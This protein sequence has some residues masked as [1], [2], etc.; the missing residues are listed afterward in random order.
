MKLKTLLQRNNNTFSKTLMAVILVFPGLRAA[1]Q[2][3][4]L[5]AGTTYTQNFDGLSN[6]AAS[7]TNSLT[8]PG[9]YMS[10]SGGGARDNGLYAVDNGATATGDTYSY[11]TAG[12]TDRALGSLR[13]GNLIPLYGASFTNNTGATIT[14]L[15]V[16]YTGEQW[17]LGTAGRTD[18]LNFEYSINATTFS[19]G[20]WTGLSALN[21]LTPTTTGALANKDGNAAG[22]RTA[23]TGT[24]T[25][26]SIANGATVWIR[27]VDIDATG[28][29]DGLAI[30]D[31]SITPVNAP[32]GSPEIDLQG[33]AVSI[34]NNSTTTSLAD[35]TDF[36][37]QSVCTGVVSHIFSILNT[38][39]ANLNLSGTPVVTVS[40]ANASD[41]TVSQPSSTVV[42]SG[43][44]TTFTVTFDPS[45]AG[46]RSA[47]LS[48]ANNDSD[49]NPYVFAIRGT[50][51]DV[52]LTLNTQNNVACHGGS[53]GAISVTASGN[54][55]L[56]YDWAPGTPTG[57]GTPAISGLSAGVY[58]VTV[59]DAGTCS[60]TASYTITEPTAIAVSVASQSGASCHGGNNGGATISASGGTGTL[61]YS[62][63]PSGG[64][65]ATASGLSAGV[66]TVTV[67]DANSCSQTQTVSI[68]EP[69]AISTSV[70]TQ[71][72]VS[73]NGGSN[74]GATISASGGTGTLV[75][76]WAPS[77]GT[78]ATA[79]GLATGV[80][81]VTVTDANTCSKTQT[82]SISEPTALAVSV[83]TQ[84]NVSCN[85]GNNGGA[86]LSANGGTGTLTY[87]WFPSGGTAATASG[88]VAGTYTVTVTDANTCAKS[89][90]L[91]ITQPAAIAVSVVSQ[92]SVSCQGGSNGSAVAFANGGS[93]TLG[94]SWAPS[95]GTA[96][97]A[98]GLSAGI[99]T[100]TVTDANTCSKSQTVSITQPAA[101]AVSVVSQSS[102]SCHGGGNGSATVSA[103][104]GTGSLGYSWAP[105]GG[106]AATATGLS[107]GI[108]TVTVTDANTCTKSQTV[109]VSEPTAITVSVPTKTNVSCYA[110]SN[111]RASV[112]ASGGTGTLSYLWSPSGITSAT[113]NNLT[114]GIYTVTVK[115]ANNCSQ[116]QTVSITEPTE[117]TVSAVTPTNVSCHGGSN[118]S[119]GVSAS[120]GTGTLTYSWMPSGGTGTTATGL[121][122][123][124]YTLTVKDANACASTQT[125]SISEPLA[126]TASV[127]STV[128]SCAANTGIASV[129]SVSGGTGAYTYSWSPSGGTAA[130]AT[131]LGSGIYTVTVKDANLCVF[132][133]TANI[134]PANTPTLTVASQTNVA[135]FGGNNGAGE[136]NPATG[137]AGAY[138]YSWSPAGGTSTTASGL[139]VGAYTVTVK[140]ANNCSASQVITITGP[141]AALTASVSAGTILCHGGVSTLT[142][143]ANGG[144]PAYTGTGTFTATAGTYSYSVTDS[145][146]CANTASITVSEPATLTASV[147]ASTILCHGGI[148]TLTVSANGGTPAYTGA[149]TFTATAGTYSYTVT[150][151]HGCASTASLTVTEPAAIT[152]SQ[153]K[154][155]CAGQSLV[156]GIHTYTASGTYTDVLSNAHGCDSTVTTQ[157]TVRAP[158]VVTTTLSGNGNTIS[159]NTSPAT[160]Q[161]INCNGNTP[162]SG[163]TS[164]SFTPVSSGSYAVIITVG[165]CSNTSS[166]VTVT[167]S[168]T[169]IAE[170]AAETIQV[171]P[172][173]S[174]GQ[175][176]IELQSDN[177]VL[178]MTDL[179]GKVVYSQPVKQGKQEINV[180]HLEEGIYTMTISGPSGNSTRRVM[181]SK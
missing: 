168:S 23:I 107:A 114:A 46:I 146:G 79:T 135:C 25:G 176:I 36:G 33:N 119:A 174:T 156:V 13:S 76:S 77:G 74:G 38:G 171:Y 81:T 123:G 160:Y 105:S 63:A 100:V 148:S 31:F 90:T 6:T 72:N 124:T 95:G 134:T 128:T 116:T 110:G 4:S 173:P 99:Y 80:Y 178:I 158:I 57:D 3:I 12:A 58:S 28:A 59:T 52:T 181:I 103:S 142:V 43:G 145:H 166:C 131:G 108:Y 154:T 82:V 162:V 150:D 126:I 155:I 127:S 14:A 97:T 113:A 62:W 69:T 149:G 2:S 24:I 161:W 136:V 73:C 20:T 51:I 53:T 139:S 75:Y 83:A 48:I 121:I 86:T 40:G 167:L 78:A 151:S 85:G 98:S 19:N 5:A 60:V 177:H 9:W 180:S 111:G 94:Y 47:S 153:T 34:V 96:A 7:T 41:F 27:W 133:A 164:Q 112:S 175:F 30:D 102:V 67:T 56:T 159:A 104:G 71:T 143:S 89:Q 55:T 109:S 66:Y 152:A 130:T 84:T 125:F 70:A 93:G 39:T 35:N 17:R 140:D 169:G 54:G 68:S 29:D 147:S 16:S 117:L 144:T 118:G 141:A 88:L 10:E 101:I 65:A 91:S 49:E 179:L 165:T 157:L 18:Q 129:S 32:A 170:M 92:S 42:A 22:F 11:G 44:S 122:A 45:A 26:L 1:A 163:A 106:T 132:T 115:D 138:T 120:G 50:G 61:G 37:N 172:N 64:T 15:N 8:L 87:Q 137:G 21:F